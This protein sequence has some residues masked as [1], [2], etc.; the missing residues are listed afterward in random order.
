MIDRARSLRPAAHVA[1]V[2]LPFG[3][4]GA[5]LVMF[6]A[7]SPTPAWAELD[8]VYLDRV[9]AEP[10][11]AAKRR[12]TFGDRVVQSMAPLHVGTFGGPIV[13]W[14]WFAGGLAPAM[15]FVTGCLVWWG[16]K[17]R[18]RRSDR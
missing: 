7:A 16:R 1:R 15:L 8:P 12:A 3:D 2:V 18:G 11:D 14:I 10:L 17:V 5:F 6:A 4:R 13:R 9:T